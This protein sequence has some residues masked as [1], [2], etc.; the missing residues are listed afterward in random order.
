MLVN[1]RY[2]SRIFR[3]IVAFKVE[4]YDF[5]KQ[6]AFKIEIYD[7]EKQSSIFTVFLVTSRIRY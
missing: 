4:I 3:D 7:F 6:V 1:S 5:E 2:Y